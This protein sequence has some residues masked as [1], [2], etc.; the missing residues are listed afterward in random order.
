MLRAKGED[1][2]VFVYFTRKKENACD[3][4]KDD[5][6]A[7]RGFHCWFAFCVCTNIR[8]SI[9]LCFIQYAGCLLLALFFFLSRTGLSLL[10]S[11][12]LFSFPAGACYFIYCC[13]VCCC[14][15]VVLMVVLKRV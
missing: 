13:V 11:T 15:V 4:C 8:D 2:C 7:S 14:G 5:V 9:E 1:G 6:I 3:P 10:C 12:C